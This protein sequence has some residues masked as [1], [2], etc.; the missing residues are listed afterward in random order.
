[1][2]VCPPTHLDDVPGVLSGAGLPELQPG[3]GLGEPH[4]GLELPR[5]DGHA[6]L[7]PRPTQLQVEGLQQ[8]C[9]LGAQRRLNVPGNHPPYPGMFPKQAA[10]PA[11]CAKASGMSPW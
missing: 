3:P 6:V 11:P 2:E 4:Q 7:A 10:D 8:G 1:M 5:R 9:T